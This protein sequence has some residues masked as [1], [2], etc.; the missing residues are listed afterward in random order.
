V[1]VSFLVFVDKS[2]LKVSLRHSNSVWFFNLIVCGF[3]FLWL[4][5]GEWV[6]ILGIQRYE[7]LIVWQKAMDLVVEV[8]KILKLMPNDELYALSDQ[9]KRAAV[10]IPSN[11]AEGQERNTTKDFVKFLHIAKG[12]KAELETQLL[13]CVRLNYLTQVHIET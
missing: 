13:I 8:Y 9:M 3:R 10:S 12:S 5:V 7:D 1:A 6:G 2:I 4:V 11:I